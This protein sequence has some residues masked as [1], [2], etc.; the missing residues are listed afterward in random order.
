[1]KQVG[2]KYAEGVG[3]KPPT[4]PMSPERNTIYHELSLNV[5]KTYVQDLGEDSVAVLP[6]VHG[7][8]DDRNPPYGPVPLDGGFDLLTFHAP[9]VVVPPDHRTGCTTV[10]ARA[11]R[12]RV[13][14]EPIQCVHRK[15][16]EKVDP[17]RQ[18]STRVLVVHKQ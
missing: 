10:S 17:D 6:V 7:I 16:K 14:E 15:G 8:L 5:F 9:N 2:A 11:E 13:I 3:V 18:R 1:M 4:M 12:K